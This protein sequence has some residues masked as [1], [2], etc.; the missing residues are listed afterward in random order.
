MTTCIYIHPVNTNQIHFVFGKSAS[1]FE[2]RDTTGLVW[3]EVIDENGVR[4]LDVTDLEPAAGWYTKEEVKQWIRR[5]RD[6]Q[7]WIRLRTSIHKVTDPG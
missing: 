7:G 6:Y 5:L 2:Q 4:F 3:I 1:P